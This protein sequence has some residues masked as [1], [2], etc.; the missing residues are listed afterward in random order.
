MTIVL[1]GGQLL[2]GIAHV[3]LIA[4]F[5]AVLS[6]LCM[7]VGWFSKKQ[8]VENTTTSQSPQEQ[9]VESTTASLMKPT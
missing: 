5:F 7:Q 3:T 9:A 2:L 6:Y 1:T 4:T 8:V